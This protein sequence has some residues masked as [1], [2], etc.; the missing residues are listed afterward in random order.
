MNFKLENLKIKAQSFLDHEYDEH[1]K[2]E[3]QQKVRDTEEQWIRLQKDA[4]EVMVLAE[5]QRA[6]DNQLQDFEA[7]REKTRMWLEEKQ[8][9][10]VFLSSQKDPEQIISTAQVSL[11]NKKFGEDIHDTQD[12]D[13]K[14]MYIVWLKIRLKYL[15]CIIPLSLNPSFEHFKM[16][17][18]VLLIVIFITNKKTRTYF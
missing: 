12:A 4:K 11:D 17:L 10:L 3:I 13:I 7:T 5:R 9:N 8:Q 2:Q 14:C 15:I 16:F 1:K 6:L 18:L